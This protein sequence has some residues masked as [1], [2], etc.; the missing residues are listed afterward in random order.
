MRVAVV[1]A[2]VLALSSPAFADGPEPAPDTELRWYGWQSLTV[3]GIAVVATAVGMAADDGSIFGGM[4]AASFATPM[5]H[6]ARRKYGRAAASFGLRAAAGVVSI[7]T[8]V[9]HLDRHQ[10]TGG[11][12]ALKLAAPFA[13][14]MAIDAGLLGWERRPIRR[15]SSIV[16]SVA[17]SDGGVMFGLGGTF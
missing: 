2:V 16:P 1:T 14:A 6:I 8:L 12:F 13:V 3:D 7:F 11:E 15:P 9:D 17:P 5:V 10:A 4:V